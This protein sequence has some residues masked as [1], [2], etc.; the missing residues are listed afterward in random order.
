MKTILIVANQT[1]AGSHLLE[2]V[3]RRMS[4]GECRFRLVVPAT[5]PSEQVV[6]TDDEA[7]ELA[8]RRL[9]AGLEALKETG[10]NIEGVVGD[11]RPM[12][13]IN[14][15]IVE[16]EFDEI[17]LSTL[18][19]GLSRWLHTDLPHRVERKFGIPV[20]HIIAGTSTAH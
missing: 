20:T 2:L 3:R 4:E 10:A 1:A 5:P 15:Q 16:Q 12:D 14:D 9:E 7:V 19:P 8:T 11:E 18:Q 6:Y 13:A 17:V